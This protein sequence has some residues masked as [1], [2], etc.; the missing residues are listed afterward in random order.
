MSGEGR[1]GGPRVGQGALPPNPSE[2]LR[3]AQALAASGHDFLIIEIAERPVKICEVDE[4][5]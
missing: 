2:V 4:R 3:S 1:P 5:A